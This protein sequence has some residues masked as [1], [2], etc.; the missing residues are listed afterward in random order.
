MD[1]FSK[2][3]HF[4]L[5]GA[6]P[7]VSYYE[8]VFPLLKKLGATG[9]LMEYEDMFPYQ[10]DLQIVC[11]PDVYSPDEIQKIHNLAS[12]N[13]LD[14]IPLVQS[15][16][17]LEF[18][19]KHDKY[20]EIRENERYPNAVCPS[21]PKSEDVIMEMVNQILDSHPTSKFIHIGGDEVWHIGQCV[22]C[23]QKMK[24][25]NWKK[26]HLFLDHITR[27][28]HRIRQRNQEI[29]III[30][31]D[32]M[33]EIDVNILMS[34][35]IGELVVPMVWHYLPIDEFK[36]KNT[37]WDN[38][39]A[40]FPNIWIASAFKGA[41]EMTQIITP[42]RYHLANQQAWLKV[43]QLFGNKFQK[44]IGIAFTGWQRFDHYTVLCEV[45][46]V[47][48]P[49]L[50][51]CLLTVI[52]GEFDEEIHKTASS[53]LGFEKPMT[54]D[55]FPRPQP[56]GPPP[57]FPGGKI[58]S[59]C[60]QLANCIAERHIL[61]HHPSLE[62]AFSKFQVMH[63]RVNTLHIDQFLPRAR[64]LLM[65]IEAV[66]VQLAEELQKVF[67]SSTVEEFLAEKISPLLQK[68]RNLVRD[69]DQQV[70]FHSPPEEMQS[71][72]S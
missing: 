26:E 59:S 13:G 14:I 70:I 21:H 15:F 44:V 46:P 48:L 34:S 6:P 4:D 25:Q 57:N 56:V 45:F 30:W 38:Y 62:G 20:Y 58:Y 60:L 9:L 35:G 24:V 1:E 29:G 19:L 10:G 5:K 36:I 64:I 3:V 8:Q 55:V 23:K 66:N 27:L 41:T 47:A 42:T 52:K 31:D 53:I 2:L 18:L 12:E 67:Y 61:F 69:A 22:V 37:L 43:L 72:S 32:M 28:V 68:L 40:I 17:H 65:N 33:R 16:G 7:L 11:Q 71:N 50:A 51:I 54:I 49:T 63:N 39:A